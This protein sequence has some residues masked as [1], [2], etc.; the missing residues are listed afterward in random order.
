MWYHLLHKVEQATSSYKVVTVFVRKQSHCTF[1][2]VSQIVQGN[3]HSELVKYTHIYHHPCVYYIIHVKHF[4]AP[5]INYNPKSYLLLLY[6]LPKPVFKYSTHHAHME[7][8]RLRTF[9]I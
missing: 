1:D 6:T 5:W 8:A 7:T 3:P 9:N 4:R 2:I